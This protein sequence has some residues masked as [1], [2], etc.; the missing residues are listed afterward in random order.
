MPSFTVV[1]KSETASWD[2][3]LSQNASIYVDYSVSVGPTSVTVSGTVYVYGYVSQI[4]KAGATFSYTGSG[5]S[6]SVDGVNVL[7]GSGTVYRSSAGGSTVSAGSFSRTIN[8]TNSR[9]S[10]SLS[11]S[12]TVS[13]YSWSARTGDPPI[14]QYGSNSVSITIPALPSCTVTVTSSGSYYQTYTPYSVSISNI[15]KD[16]DASSIRSIV[17]QV[18]SVA[19]SRSTAGS[20]SVTP[21]NAG[22]FTPIVTITDSNGS[23]QQYSLTGISV[24]PYNLPAVRFSAE[25]TDST[26]KPGDEEQSAV[27]T[28]S[29]TYT[30]PVADL[31]VP[32]VLVKDQSN[33]TVY[34]NV[35]WYA[36]RAADGT[37]SSQISSWSSVAENTDVYALL[38]GYVATT[39]TS[40]TEG[41]NYYQLVSGQYVLVQNPSGNPSTQSWYE[42]IFNTQYSYQIFI[43]P[44]DLD[45]KSHNNSGTTISQIL[46]PAFYTVDFLAGGHGIAFGQAS[47]EAGFVCDMDTVMKQGMYLG[48][49]DYQQSGSEDKALYDAIVALGWSDVLS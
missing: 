11:A 18:G 26:G 27:V 8:R 44:R 36:S 9:R 4:P 47:T 38:Y 25:R 24:N 12:G 10:I 45:I 30:D 43:T 14:S 19:D 22:S 49:P 48:L 1:S 15:T 7:S 34:V 21:P 20:L 40:V 42:E 2:A 5:I 28:A 29:F 39:D 37:L 46:G 17:L 31:A 23:Y 33:N 13:F 32:T 16:A 41:K 6:V 3:S 35:E